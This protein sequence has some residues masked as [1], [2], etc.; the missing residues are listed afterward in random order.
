MTGPNDTDRAGSKF[1][2]HGAALVDTLSLDGIPNVHTGDPDETSVQSTNQSARLAH[3]LLHTNLMNIS[4]F[5]LLDMCNRARMSQPSL[6][7]SP[8]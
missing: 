6:W 3:S 8:N 7:M 1:V 5:D 4:D 2:V